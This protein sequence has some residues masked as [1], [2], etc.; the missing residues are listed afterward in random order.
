M[1][2]ILRSIAYLVLLLLLGACGTMAG[3]D[4]V[5][6]VVNEPYKGP[7]VSITD[8]DM[9]PKM[10]Y[11]ITPDGLKLLSDLGVVC[12][13]NDAALQ[14]TY[15]KSG[16]VVY[17]ENDVMAKN[18]VMLLKIAIAPT[19]NSGSII[20]QHFKTWATQAKLLRGGGDFAC[21]DGPRD[22]QGNRS[23]DC[24]FTC[25]DKT[26]YI[27]VASFAPVKFNN[28]RQLFIVGNLQDDSDEAEITT[29]GLIEKIVY[30]LKH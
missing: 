12:K 1:N 6:Q 11:T 30:S 26:Y 7:I 22:S 17:C 13:N 25:R 9:G 28:V 16:S 19:G 4:E 24:T 18:H 27:T 10:G 23:V 8:F 15:E 14:K 3:R 2:T 29:R 20:T 21:T 5:M